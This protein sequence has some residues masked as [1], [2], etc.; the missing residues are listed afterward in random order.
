VPAAHQAQ[1]GIASQPGS[2]AAATLYVEQYAPTCND[3]GPGTQAEPFCTIQAAANVVAAGQTVDIEGDNGIAAEYA[4]AVV[5]TH[6]G[7]PTAPITFNGVV[8]PG[9]MIPDLDPTSGVPLT[10]DGVHDVTISHVAFTP[11]SNADGIDVTGSH[12]VTLDN[13]SISQQGNP[14]TNPDA[15]TVDGTSANVT[16][17]R[18]AI[19]EAS[20]SGSGSG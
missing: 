17:S 15:I 10:L 11:Y 5:V 14:T 16:V 8:P 1:A 20:A 3:S 18:S 2:A 13:V 12:E 19:I 7:T 9:G 6:S 4:Q